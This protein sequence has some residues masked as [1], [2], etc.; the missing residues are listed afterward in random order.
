MG[1]WELLTNY[2]WNFIVMNSAITSLWACY[3]LT[4]WGVFWG[5]DDGLMGQDCYRLFSGF[6]VNF[7]VS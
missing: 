6:N 3:F 2:L 7:P 1:L 4:F 5:D